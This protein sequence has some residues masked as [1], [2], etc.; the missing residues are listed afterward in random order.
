MPRQ[1][2]PETGQFTSVYDDE[3]FLNA[4]RELGQGGTGEIAELVGCSDDH[5]YRRLRSLQEDGRVASRVV[6][7]AKLWERVDGPN[8]V[9]PDDPFFSF[10]PVA[11]GEHTDASKTDEYLYGSATA[12]GSDADE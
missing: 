2:D 8:G 9:N 12:D 1:Q 6:G 7:G 11:S 10:E 4:L 5:A 3:A